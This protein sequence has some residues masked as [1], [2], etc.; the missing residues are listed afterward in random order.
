MTLTEFDSWYRERYKRTSSWVITTAMIIADFIGIMAS[1]GAGF[2]VVKI[3]FILNDNWGGIAFYSFITYWPYLPVFILLFV[4]MRLYPGVSLAPAE[5]LKGVTIGSFMAHGS[6]VISLYISDEVVSSITV[7][8]CFSFFIS[9]IVI[10]IIRDFMNFLLYKI[11]LGHI[12]AVIYGA[13]K[14][15]QRVADHLL[16]S[17]RAGYYPVLILDDD[18]ATGEEYRGIPIIHDTM[19]G[20]DLVKTYNIKMA[21]VAMPNLE[22]SKMTRMMNFSVSAFRYTVLI[23]AFFNISNIWM[24]V[25]D[26]DGIL[27]FA[28]SNKLT[29]KWN[30]VIKRLIDVS[31][32]SIGGL[33]LLPFL[34]IIA[35]LVKLGSS[36]PVLY[37]HER[38]GVNGKVFKAYKFR[39]MVVDADKQLNDILDKDPHLRREWENGQ[40]LKNDPRV[41]K[42]GKFLRRTSFDEFPQLINILK[43]EMGLV[44]PRPVVEAEVEKYGENFKRIFSVKPGLTGL[45]QI[46]GRSDTDYLERIS[47]D[48]YYIQSWSVW[49]DL[50]IIYRTPMAIIRGRGAY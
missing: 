35:L 20:P 39:S 29:R 25:R 44:G 28:T 19:I 34:L 21:I 23:P 40:K 49:L 16:G 41:T 2:F 14:M 15:G 33:L 45:W 31:I 12:P 17:T 30:L 37:C 36:G 13:N 10:M 38:L 46:S 7:S 9:I 4:I 1:I 5:E 32:V 42:I 48:T 3:Y 47:Y 27:G 26:F 18:A 11:H 22:Q 43:G 50:W 24:S 6:I 8:F